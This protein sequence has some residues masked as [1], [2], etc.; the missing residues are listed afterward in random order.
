MGT[1]ASKRS[2]PHGLLPAAHGTSEERE[3]QLLEIRL[4]EAEHHAAERLDELYQKLDLVMAGMFVFPYGLLCKPPKGHVNSAHI[5]RKDRENK[6]LRM[7]TKLLEKPP[8]EEIW[9]FRNDAGDWTS[10]DTK[11]SAQIMH[12]W[13]NNFTG[14]N[15]FEVVSEGR[16]YWID[17]NK[18][19]QR[20]ENT[21]KVRQIRCELGLPAHWGISEEIG[22]K[23]LRASKIEMVQEVPRHESLFHRL[24]TVLNLSVFRHD[25]TL[26]QCLHGKSKFRLLKAYQV[27]NLYL[28]RRYQRFVK[29]LHE[30]HRTF[31]TCCKGLQPSVSYELMALA[32]N[33]QVDVEG[34]ERLL[35]HGTRT[36]EL[37]KT[38][39][40]EGFDNRVANDTCLYGK[41]TYFAMQTCKA[42]QYATLN[43]MNELAS[44][45]Q[46]GTIIL[47]RVALGDIYEAPGP[48][49]ESRSLAGSDL[50]CCIWG[51][52]DKCCSKLSG[53]AC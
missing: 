4:R 22:L 5:V 24:Q 38:I 30:K 32:Q 41:G 27:C 26:C 2:L 48:F 44:D 12:R 18:R 42:A 36:P 52:P 13:K 43:A 45:V 25:Q 37:A 10:Y 15:A 28:W 19:E 21:G 40:K 6:D 46:P 11:V 1:C 29:S 53:G 9:Q 33:L 49:D 50:E 7:Q 8:E 31:K 16:L 23:M 20:A 47:A 17:L 3:R 35:L 34:N 14:E 39:A 51:V